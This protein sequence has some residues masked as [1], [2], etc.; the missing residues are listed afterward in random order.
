ME[1]SLKENDIYYLK[2]T[3]NNMKNDLEETIGLLSIIMQIFSD[4]KKIK[5]NENNVMNN[6]KDYINNLKNKIN[7]IIEKEKTIGK[8]A[9]NNNKIKHMKLENKI[10]DEHDLNYYNE[11]YINNIVKDFDKK[12]KE[13]QNYL[14]MKKEN[15]NQLINKI[16]NSV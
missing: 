11:E 12:I 9:K 4:V 5:N 1:L 15:L 10:T 16:Y 8:M 14:F 2:E 3:S 13:K 7:L 6:I